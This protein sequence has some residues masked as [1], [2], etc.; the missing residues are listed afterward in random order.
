MFEDVELRPGM[1]AVVVE[2][3]MEPLQLNTMTKFGD[4][5]DVRRGE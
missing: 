3:E 4:K 2:A 1:E 5:Q